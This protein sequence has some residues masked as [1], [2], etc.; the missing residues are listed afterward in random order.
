ML[1]LCQSSN[2]EAGRTEGV[3]LCGGVVLGNVRRG[4]AADSRLTR[5]H[6][7]GG[8]GRIRSGDCSHTAPARHCHVVLHPAIEGKRLG[9]TVGRSPFFTGGNVTRKLDRRIAD[10]YV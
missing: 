9:D 7:P 3:A 10:I 4:R 8:R 1:Y 5:I 2:S 6:L